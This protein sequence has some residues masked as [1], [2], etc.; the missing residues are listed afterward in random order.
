MSGNLRAGALTLRI[1]NRFDA[2]PA[3]TEVIE[4]FCRSRGVPDA[5]I[6]HVNLALDEAL[7]NTI[8][9]AWPQGGDHEAT[10]TLRIGAKAVE[11]EVSDDGVP[12][13]PLDTP[14]PDLEADI[15]ARAIGGLGVHVI[16][17]LMDTV[18]YR[19]AGDRNV[20]TLRK[21]F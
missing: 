18:N 19:R 21:S 5:T 11:V 6:G 20:L 14:S 15:D 7:T 12:F 10:V 2:I 17:T 13:D 8:S 4:R 16:R 9:Y 3:A 1:A